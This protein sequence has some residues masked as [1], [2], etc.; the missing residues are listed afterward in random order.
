M[1]N[2]IRNAYVAGERTAKNYRVGDVFLGATPEAD[3]QGFGKDPLARAAFMGSYLKN[4][5]RP[6]ITTRDNVLLQYGQ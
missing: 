5:A 6:I 1:T 2:L 3:R 4:L